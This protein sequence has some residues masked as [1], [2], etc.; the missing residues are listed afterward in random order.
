[1]KSGEGTIFCLIINHH[2]V[3]IHLYSG[4]RIFSL[5]Y[6]V[7]Y[8]MCVSGGGG[9]AGQEETFQISH[10]NLPFTGQTICLSLKFYSERETE[11]VASRA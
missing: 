8:G 6:R 11:T 4:M 9:D 5:P 7:I 2:V 1:M 10:A 3:A